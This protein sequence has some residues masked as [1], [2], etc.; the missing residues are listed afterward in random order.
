MSIWFISDC[1]FGHKNI[2]EYCNRPFSSVYEMDNTLIQYWND[3]V[4]PQDDIYHLGDFSFSPRTK[5]GDKSILNLLLLLHGNKHFIIGNHDSNLVR[6]L[7][8][9]KNWEDYK[10]KSLEYYKEIKYNHQLFCL[11]HFGQR[12]WNKSHHGSVHLFGHSHGTLPAHGKSVDVGV[13]CKEITSEYRPIH[14]DEIIEFM[15]DREIFR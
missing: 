12:V 5:E 6:V 1:H 15:E 9:N 14:I 13:D 4:K 7:N 11:Y 8:N 2:I 10:V 3:E